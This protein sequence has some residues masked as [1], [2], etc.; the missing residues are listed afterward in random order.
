MREGWKLAS[1]AVQD[2]IAMSL[3][4]D[5]VGRLM[6]T[7][8]TPGRGGWCEPRVWQALV[9]NKLGSGKL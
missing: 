6:A 3:N 4:G 9:K 8:E 2:A 1:R 7:G 5:E